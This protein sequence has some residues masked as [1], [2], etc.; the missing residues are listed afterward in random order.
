MH[1][2]R[3]EAPNETARQSIRAKITEYLSR[4]ETLKKQLRC[5]AQSTEQAH[6]KAEDPETKRL[7]AQ[8]EGAIITERPNVKW[9]DVAGLEAAKEALK[10]AVIMP[11]LFPE[12]FTGRLVL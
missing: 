8:L 7:T 2:S 9:S 4:A 6:A 5:A 11:T 10:E 12:L 1:S 3:Y